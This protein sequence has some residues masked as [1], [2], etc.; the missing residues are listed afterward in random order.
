MPKL[1]SA[2]ELIVERDALNSPNDFVNKAP[3]LYLLEDE[4]SSPRNLA[5]D[6]AASLVHAHFLFIGA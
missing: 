3:S 6:E 1:F 5:A 4:S 2:I